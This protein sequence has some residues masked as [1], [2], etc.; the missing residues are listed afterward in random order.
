MSGRRGMGRPKFV[1]GSGLLGKVARNLGS[2]ESQNAINS[3]PTISPPILKKQEP[4]KIPDISLPAKVKPEIPEEEEF[5][6]IPDISMPIPKK[7]I[8]SEAVPGSPVTPNIKEN[9]ETNAALPVDQ[10]KNESSP[11][12]L[13]TRTSKI[14]TRTLTGPAVFFSSDEEDDGETGQPV[15][16][17]EV[18]SE[19]ENPISTLPN[20]TEEEETTTISPIK[21]EENYKSDPIQ[22]EP[23]EMSFEDALTM[24]RKN[25]P[26]KPEPEPES[27][28]IVEQEKPKETDFD[29]EEINTN[30]EI[31]IGDIRELEEDDRIIVIPPPKDCFDFLKIF[32]RIAGFHVF[33]F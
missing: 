27:S 21:P 8:N 24:M 31:E 29:N 14:V 15:L 5:E 28:E 11:S 7:Q 17:P 9:G 2:D 1:T 12:D 10:E 25:K 26:V 20:I 19:I 4:E 30:V 13:I 18:P 16:K 3:K 6:N 23:V 33:C 32:L 22:I